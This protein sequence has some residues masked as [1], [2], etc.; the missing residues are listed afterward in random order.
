MKLLSFKTLLLS[1]KMMVLAYLFYY[2]YTHFIVQ[3]T[4]RNAIFIELEKGLNYQKIFWLIIAIILLP[5]NWLLES[6]KWFVLQNSIG[7]SSFYTC[8]K[9]VIKGVSYGLLVPQQIGDLLGKTDSNEQKNKSSIVVLS[10]FGGFIQ[11]FIAL[12]GGGI[13]FFA[14]YKP[15]NLLV[16]I[17][18]ICIIILPIFLLIFNFNYLFKILQNKF[19]SFKSISINIEKIDIV[20]VF[21][22]SFLRYNIFVFQFYCILNLFDFILN[23]MQVINAIMLTYLGKTFIPALNVFGDLGTREF[24]A[25]LSFSSTLIPVHIVFLSSMMVW[26]LNILIPGILGCYYMF[27]KQVLNS[28]KY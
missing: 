20:K 27:E 26:L 18:I 12:I 9:N 25:I 14:I 1:I 5:I 28:N 21:I 16:L 23:K 13:A 8:W 19:N 17:L 3:E 15:V 11:S 6:Y 2:L 10:L 24:S 4:F 22:A 7:I